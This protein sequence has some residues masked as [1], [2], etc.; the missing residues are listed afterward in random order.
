M[1][2][3]TSSQNTFSVDRFTFAIM[4]LVWIWDSALLAIPILIVFDPLSMMSRFEVQLR[5]LVVIS[6]LEN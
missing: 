4:F 6:E 3:S 1:M 2:R 5:Q